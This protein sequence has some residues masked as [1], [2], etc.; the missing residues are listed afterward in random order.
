[1]RVRPAR[2]EV[3]GGTKE[4][5]EKIDISERTGNEHADENRPA[6]AGE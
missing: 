6:A 4:G 2:D 1:M 5:A 3:G